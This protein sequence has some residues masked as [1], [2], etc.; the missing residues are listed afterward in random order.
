MTGTAEVVSESNKIDITDI[1]D[2]P[3]VLQILGLLNHDKYTDTTVTKNWVTVGGW[4]R[5]SD[6]L[7]TY[8][9]ALAP[10]MRTQGSAEELLAALK[11]T[12][13]DTI[14]VKANNEYEFSVL[15]YG[16]NNYR[17]EIQWDKITH[18]QTHLTLPDTV[19]EKNSFR[20]KQQIDIS[21]L[22]ANEVYETM[23]QWDY[24]TKLLDVPYVTQSG[25]K[26]LFDAGVPFITSNDMATVNSIFGESPSIF[27]K[28]IMQQDSWKRIGTWTYAKLRSSWSA[29]WIFDK[30]T[31]TMQV[32]ASEWYISRNDENMALPI[33]S[34]EK[35]Q[36][37]NSSN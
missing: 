8:L 37:N 16:R 12:V 32:L 5:S 36:T 23:A 34:V 20:N 10:T 6:T 18:D 27:T 14:P 3:F 17:Q 33:L 13:I 15:L 11:N 7:R 4:H 28:L 2:S 29:T 30:K 35:I 19:I 9:Q 21:L 1:Q 31:N 25:A 24:G 22:D 26:K